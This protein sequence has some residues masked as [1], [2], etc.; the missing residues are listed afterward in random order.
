MDRLIKY[1]CIFGGGGV[2]G[3]CY[4]GVLRALKELNIEIDNI[5]GS[6]VGA[7]FA[8]LLVEKKKK[9]EIQEMF[10]NFN[11]NMFRD[12]NINI[13]NT[14]IS[15]SKG[16]IFLDWLREKIGKKVLGD[17]YRENSKVEFK[18]LD[19]N[20]HILTLDINTNTPYIFSKD[21]T[22][23][24]E[25]AFAIRTSACMP[26]LMKPIN[27][28]ESILVDGDLIKSW[29]GC[30]IYNDL[31]T[32]NNRI[33]EFRLEGKKD[34]TDFKNPV[35]YINSVISTIW[36]LCTE[37]VYNLNHENDRYDYIILDTKD[38]VFFDFNIDRNKK[39][40]L[41]E[42]GYQITKNYF[43]NV[44]IDKKK[45][46]L[47]VYKKILK[48]LNYLRNAINKNKPLDAVFT[49]NEILSS[50]F[51]D[52][53][54]IDSSIYFKIKDFKESIITNTK[55]QFIFSSKMDNEKQIKE[56]CEFIYMLVEERILEIEKYIN[57][58]CNKS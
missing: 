10:F 47:N 24:E 8:G 6:S 25:V 52:L 31:D 55:K 14:D 43:Q 3:M 32:S 17:K 44:I 26:G 57:L 30:K 29:A 56:R 46:I 42:K 49:I 38:V 33:L 13:F 50:M 35:D 36:Y 15:L 20:L 9:K 41:A 58:H 37:N 1:N 34:S 45:N 22:P 39:E 19:K 21:N 54:Y 48:N 40:K 4:V 51:E 16:E 27:L 7:V 12:I 11:F 2:R 28:G 53:K 18:D 5:A 23:D